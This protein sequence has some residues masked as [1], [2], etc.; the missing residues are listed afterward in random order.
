MI[1]T[2]AGVTTEVVTSPTSPKIRQDVNGNLSI[3][4]EFS[5]GWNA[6]LGAN[7]ALTDPLGY[8]VPLAGYE[9]NAREA[10][11]GDMVVEYR[12]TINGHNLSITRLDPTAPT[13]LP[14]D[15][16]SFQGAVFERPIEQWPD[17]KGS[18]YLGT[19]E[20]TRL[21]G[22]A[23]ISYE[24]HA[25]NASYGSG[26]STYIVTYAESFYIGGGV[27]NR[28]VYGQ[29]YPSLNPVDRLG[30]R[31][32][33]GG[34]CFAPYATYWLVIAADI[35]R[36]AEDVWAYSENYQLNKDGWDTNIYTAT[37]GPLA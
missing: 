6:I 27:Y 25:I 13:P 33:V 37:V 16:E 24:A 21:V 28:V 10:G 20:L 35:K 18:G 15:E 26:T 8:G 2:Y 32:S 7:P 9:K 4:Y 17:G 5:G 31:T 3:V 1:V 22:G 11:L 12:R 29:T 30:K 19:V 36:T 34:L 14:E 23:T